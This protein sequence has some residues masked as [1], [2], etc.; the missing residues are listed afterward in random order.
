MAPTPRGVS[1]LIQV[2]EAG[3]VTSQALLGAAYGL[4]CHIVGSGGPGRWSCVGSCSLAAE[5]THPEGLQDSGRSLGLSSGPGTLW[6]HLEW[7][8][9]SKTLLGLWTLDSE[10]WGAGVS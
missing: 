10:M 5:R 6:G 9:A 2:L 1:S 3:D 8:K 4:R 7:S